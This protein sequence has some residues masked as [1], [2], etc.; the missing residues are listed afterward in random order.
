MGIFVRDMGSWIYANCHLELHMVPHIKITHW[1]PIVTFCPVNG[2]PDLI[3]IVLEFQ[4]GKFHELYQIR[5]KIRRLVQWRKMFMEDVCALVASEFPE[6]LTIQTALLF[7]KHV[8]SIR[9]N[10]EL[11]S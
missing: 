10:H 9:R 2:L 5:K 11:F 1:F 6:A 4:D 3:Y 7:G 8:V